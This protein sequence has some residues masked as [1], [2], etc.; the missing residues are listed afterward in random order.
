[1]DSSVTKGLDALASLA[2]ATDDGGR[3]GP[4]VTASELARRMDRDRSQLSRMLTAMTAEE[5]AVR[6]EVSG[7]FAPHWRLYATARDLTA[8]RLRTDGL[9]ALEGM[10]AE[11]GESCYL[12]VLAGDTTVTIAERVPP[13][14]RQLGSWIGRPFPAY[15]SDCGQALLSDADDE[16]VAAVF[17]RTEF[18]RHGPNTPTGLD[19]FLSRLEATRRRGYSIVDE[20]AE[21]LLYSVAVPVR[22]FSDEVVAA[23]QVVGPRRRL[24]PRTEECVTAALRWAGH[25]ETALRGA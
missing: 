16:E 5:F 17:A 24:Q 6:D 13:G 12:G 10:A 2:R 11:T 9:T 15:C 20:E 18:V 23:V 1:M 7:G 21:P 4:A 8:H 25:L 22:D 14:S 3:H 19:D